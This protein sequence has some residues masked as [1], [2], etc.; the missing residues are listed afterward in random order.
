MV[1]LVSFLDAPPKN[2]RTHSFRKHDIM[3]EKL[4]FPGGVVEG[5]AVSPQ[6]ARGVLHAYR[7]L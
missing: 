7:T 6:G 1:S 3:E 2:S 4:V 5:W